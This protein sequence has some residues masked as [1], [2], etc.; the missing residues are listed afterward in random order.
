MIMKFE[1]DHMGSCICQWSFVYLAN[2]ESKLSKTMFVLS[3]G[4]NR[5]IQHEMKATV[6]M[7]LSVSLN[8]DHADG[9]N[10]IMMKRK[11]IVFMNS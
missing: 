6:L 7:L 1:P 9:N 8:I 3:L 2:E 5:H 10:D 4:T 11:V